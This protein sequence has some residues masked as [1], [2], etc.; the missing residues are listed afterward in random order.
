MKKMTLDVLLASVM[1]IPLNAVL[2][3][4]IPKV[5]VVVKKQNKHD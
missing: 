1:D 2:P 5:I 3:L 4:A